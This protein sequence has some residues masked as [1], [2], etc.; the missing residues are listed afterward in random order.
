MKICKIYIK[1][2]QQFQ[3]VALD[4][5]NPETGEA[6]DKVCFIGSNGTGK[7]T[8]LGQIKDG[9]NQISDVDSLPVNIAYKRPLTIFEFKFESQ[10]LYYIISDFQVGKY[11]F[12]SN[13]RT[14]TPAIF[15][16]L[17]NGDDIDLFLTKI[18]SENNTNDLSEVI[19]K[20][21]G[22]VALFI[23]SPS[24]ATSTDSLLINDVPETTVNEAL[25][26]NSGFPR[27]AMVSPDK[28]NIFWK[29]LVYNIRKREEDR[30]RYEN[31]PENLSKIKQQLITEFDLMQPKVLNHLNDV[32][33]RILSKA[34]LYFDVK[35]A[36]NPYQL[37]DNLKAYIRL[38]SN[39]KHIP[40]NELSSGIRNYI[41]RIGHIFSLYFNRE[42]DLGFLLVDEPENS[43]YPD[44]LFELVETYQQIILDKRGENNTQM[45]FATHNPIIAAQF[46]PY[47]RIILEWTEDGTV[48]ANKGTTPEGDDPNDILKKDF[49]LHQLMGTVGIQQWNKYLD[50]KREL[51]M[52]ESIEEK[53]SVAAE[54]NKI[55]QLY[56]FPG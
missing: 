44:F 27:Y 8:I 15:A 5:T 22:K 41:F 52:T 20:I 47:E 7:S 10:F 31:T 16:E 39:D 18:K 56:N 1:G 25:S 55:G 13:K 43:L 14:I 37:T 19:K 45:F 54:I 30:D 29:I 53:M 3:D 12:F 32:W 35:G 46:K 42:I 40:Y 49:G 23:N 48:K 50:L 24:E 38:K 4:F 2:F 9:L 11:A 34:G 51:K 17:K 28:I 21:Q 26:L 33:E 36:S 6:V